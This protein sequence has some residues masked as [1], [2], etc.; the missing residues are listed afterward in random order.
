MGGSVIAQMKIHIGITNGIGLLL[1]LSLLLGGQY[2]L[3]GYI[4]FFGALSLFVIHNSCTFIF[5]RMN[6]SIVFLA[7][8]VLIGFVVSLFHRNSLIDS[9]GDM[10]RYYLIFFIIFVIYNSKVNSKQIDSIFRSFI[11]SFF[12]LLLVCYFQVGMKVKLLETNTL[13]TTQIGSD[14]FLVIC[15]ILYRKKKG[16]MS[17]LAAIGLIVVEYLAESRTAL[18][19]SLLLIILYC[20]FNIMKREFKHANCLFWLWIVLCLAIPAIYVYIYTSKYNSMIEMLF[21]KYTG[22]RF[23][24]GRQ[25]MWT[26]AFDVF[27]SNS[28]LGKGVGFRLDTSN[29]Y[30]GASEGMSVHNFFL[31][32]LLQ[33]GIIGFA[34]FCYMFYTFW[35]RYSKIGTNQAN[36]MRAF[37]LAVLLQQ[38]FSL[39]LVSGKMGFA[40]VCWFLMA[41][42]AKGNEN[43]CG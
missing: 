13:V 34:L 14:I 12:V 26:R 11:Y 9:L 5:D 42:G 36:C 18:F 6:R 1:S 37:L 8:A 27:V 22:H 15:A 25:F 30:K 43:N 7:I 38:T 41:I 4:G 3:L 10:L 2:R 32:V 17:A 31:Y 33:M 29:L 20:S 23:F 40:F 24:S 21:L 19:A 16:A 28:I 35:K 39:G